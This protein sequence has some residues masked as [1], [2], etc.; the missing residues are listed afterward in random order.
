LYT[1]TW[2]QRSVVE[3]PTNSLLD[4]NTFSL[5]CVSFLNALFDSG[6]TKFSPCVASG[7]VIQVSNISSGQKTTIYCKSVSAKQQNS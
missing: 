6:E 3:T 5:L 7:Y 4:I 1:R 2:V